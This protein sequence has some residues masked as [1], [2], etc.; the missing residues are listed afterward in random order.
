[1]RYA[2]Q[3]KTSISGVYLG[4]YVYAG[5]KIGEVGA[6]GYTIPQGEECAAHLHFETIG[7]SGASVLDYF[8]WGN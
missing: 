5:Q 3:R 4:A 8:E 6:T 1:M 2:H 7:N